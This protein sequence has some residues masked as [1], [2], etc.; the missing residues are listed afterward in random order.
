M[1]NATVEEGC[2]SKSSN[3]QGPAGWCQQPSGAGGAVLPAFR[4]RTDSVIEYTPPS[5]GE[6]AGSTFYINKNGNVDYVVLLKVSLPLQTWPHQLLRT[7]YRQTFFWTFAQKLKVKK[8]KTQD[9]KNE[10]E[11]KKF[12]L[13]TQYSG[14]FF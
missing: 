14:K 5:V 12:S 9:K 1:G 13:T 2:S 11:L 7:I 4:S 6:A 8:T 3:Q 10:R